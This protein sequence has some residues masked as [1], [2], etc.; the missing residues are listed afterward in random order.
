MENTVGDAVA[1]ADVGVAADANVCVI[2]ALVAALCTIVVA[3]GTVTVRKMVP[4]G[5]LVIAVPFR[6]VLASTPDGACTRVTL[7]GVIL[8]EAP[9]VRCY[10][11]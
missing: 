5:L 9:D 3:C 7:I 6:R 8:G 1:V 11:T 10:K 2:P 4:A